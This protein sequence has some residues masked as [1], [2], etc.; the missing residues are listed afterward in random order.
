MLKDIFYQM[1]IENKGYINL[2]E[3]EDFI[4]NFFNHNNLAVPSHEIIN[5][6]INEIFK[7]SNK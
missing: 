6:I 3:L 7:K 2:Q 4:K 1:D 5:I